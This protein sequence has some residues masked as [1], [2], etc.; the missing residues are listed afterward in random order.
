M[1]TNSEEAPPPEPRSPHTLLVGG[2]ALA[3]AACRLAAGTGAYVA[4]LEDS[5][6][7]DP[8]SFLALPASSPGG[9]RSPIDSS[10]SSG[11]SVFWVRLWQPARLFAWM[12]ANQSSHLTILGHVA[13][14]GRVP[15]NRDL[16]RDDVSVAALA[17]LEGGDDT[18]LRLVKHLV[19]QQG[20]TLCAVQRFFPSLLLTRLEALTSCR[21]LGRLSPG[22]RRGTCRAPGS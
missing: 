14:P 12:K 13:R 21:F 5:C 22:Y 10:D 9:E 2:G 15:S 18:L 6:D 1:V 8:A 3:R 4:A 17:G 20:I 11:P 16:G 19:E 7:F